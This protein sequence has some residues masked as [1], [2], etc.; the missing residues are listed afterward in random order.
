MV[1]KAVQGTETEENGGYWELAGGGGES[2][3]GYSFR[4]C[5]T[6]KF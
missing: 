5:R 1:R 4:G 2:L 6:K 3:N